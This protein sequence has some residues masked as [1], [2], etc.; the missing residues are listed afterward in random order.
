MTPVGAIKLEVARSL[1]EEEPGW[2]L[3]INIGAEF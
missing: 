2:R 3:H 1:S